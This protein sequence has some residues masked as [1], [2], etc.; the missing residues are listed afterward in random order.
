MV[1]RRA[2]ASRAVGVMAAAV[3]A[4]AATGLAVMV[5]AV[6][7]VGAASEAA[8]AA[9]AGMVGVLV[10]EEVKAVAGMAAAVRST[11]DSLHTPERF[12]TCTPRSANDLHRCTKPRRE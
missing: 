2:V 6:K 1:A 7:V 10:A 5:A 3:R 12:D 11:L 4:A 9:E 8:W